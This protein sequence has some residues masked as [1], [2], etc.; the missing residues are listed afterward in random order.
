MQIVMGELSV[1][2]KKSQTSSKLCLRV[3]FYVKGNNDMFS[4]RNKKERMQRLISSPF[5][6]DDVGGGKIDKM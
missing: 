2:P 6:D 5:L 3:W 4:L 1:Q